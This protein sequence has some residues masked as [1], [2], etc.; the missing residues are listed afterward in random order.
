MV[1]AVEVDVEAVEVVVEVV[2]EAVVDDVVD[3]VVEVEDA[4]V[5]YQL[6]LTETVFPSKCNPNQ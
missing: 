3:V 5:A 2:V 6:I 1:D 4:V